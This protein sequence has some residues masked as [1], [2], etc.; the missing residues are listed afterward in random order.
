MIIVAVSSTSSVNVEGEAPAHE[1]V[2][3]GEE[4][5]EAVRE[6]LET[7]S[8]NLWMDFQ[9]FCKCFK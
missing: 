7:K 4:E 5:Q 6:E 9:E 8:E 2:V 1:S 3:M